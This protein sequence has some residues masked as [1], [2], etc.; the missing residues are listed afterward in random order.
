ML[1][2]HLQE[3]GFLIVGRS[4]R[5]HRFDRVVAIGTAAQ[6]DNPK[7]HEAFDPI[8]HSS[9]LYVCDSH[10]VDKINVDGIANTLVL[11]SADGE[12]KTTQAVGESASACPYAAFIRAPEKDVGVESLR[13]M[14][15]DFLLSLKELTADLERAS[16]ANGSFQ[17]LVDIGEEFFGC[18]MNVT[19]PNYVLLAH[20]THIEP[21][22]EINASLVKLGYHTE[23]HLRLQ[24]STGYL[25]E[26]VAE[27]T[28]VCVHPPEGVFPYSLI[29]SVMHV[30]GQY[31][32]HVLMACEAEEITAGTVDLFAL[33]S[34]YCERLTRRKT[35]VLPMQNSASQAL[36]LRLI[37]EK[38]I[39]GIFLR[40]QAEQLGI[41]M[42]GTFALAQ[43]DYDPALRSQLAYFATAIDKQIEASHV[44][45]LLGDSIA[46]L[47]FGDTEAILWNALVKT[48]ET[49]PKGIRPQTYVSD[50]F[51]KLSGAYCGYR[52]VASIKKY[53]QDIRLCLALTGN[54]ERAGMLCFRDAFCFYWED[55]GADEEIRHF[56]LSHLLVSSIAQNDEKRRTDDLALLFTFLANE[57]K[58]T[59]VGSICHLHRNG[60]L[61]RIGKMANEYGFDPNDYLTRQYLQVSIRIKLAASQEF[62]QL[63]ESA[64]ALYAGDAQPTQT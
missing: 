4:N 18:F 58:A 8:A 9:T 54:E 49:H 25:L 29:T 20:T 41:P 5:N 48:R 51:Y 31:A 60:V 35:D 27:Q 16:R 63:L 38:T 61:Y 45:F 11:V 34:S 14:I 39:D 55:S 26:S 50:A 42:S 15:L 13:G 22:D 57:R 43:F 21:E 64:R 47:L 12:L 36:L 56:S 52:Q 32:G 24:R 30:D 62:S 17:K 6:T 23:S 3:S 2:E 1:L 46:I 7:S 33:F 59:L 40:E 53:E 28:G 19:D 10:D 37:A 44:V